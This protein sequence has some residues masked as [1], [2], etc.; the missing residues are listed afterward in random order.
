MNSLAFIN[1]AGPAICEWGKHHNGPCVLDQHEGIVIARQPNK[2]TD[3]FNNP[4]VI[5]SFEVVS[6]LTQARWSQVASELH[7][8]YCKELKCQ[9]NQ[10]HKK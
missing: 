2:K 9:T 5:S 10:K 8:L 7:N 3:P 4:L 6:G 1:K